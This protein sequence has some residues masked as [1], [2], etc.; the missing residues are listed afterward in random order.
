MTTFR[1]LKIFIL[2]LWDFVPD[3]LILS[4]QY[5]IKTGR[6]LNWKNPQRFSEKLQLYKLGAK[7][8]PELKQ[9]VDKFDVRQF[10]RNKGLSEILIPLATNEIDWKNLPNQFVIKDSLG[11]GGNKKYTKNYNRTRKSCKTYF[12]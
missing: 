8:H 3:E 11:G 5:R 4:L 1:N 2:S 12:R 10:V 9:C 6:K 7:N